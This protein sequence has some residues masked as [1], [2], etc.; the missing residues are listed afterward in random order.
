MEAVWFRKGPCSMKNNLSVRVGRGWG[1]GKSQTKL[2]GGR[3]VTNKNPSLFP[4]LD[5]KREKTLDFR[6]EGC[7]LYM[8]GGCDELYR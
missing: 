6:Y 3:R 7:R 2:E 8:I 1:K 4:G 5:L